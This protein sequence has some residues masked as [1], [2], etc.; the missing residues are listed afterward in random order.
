MSILLLSDIWI[1][2]FTLKGAKK[3]HC[4]QCYRYFNDLTGTVFDIHNFSLGGYVTYYQ[5]DGGK[6]YPST[7]TRN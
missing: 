3:Y 7:L 6:A 4:Q 2:D 1:D 5:G